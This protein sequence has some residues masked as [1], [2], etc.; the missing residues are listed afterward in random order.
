[1]YFD[2]SSTFQGGG[3][4]VVLT[5]LFNQPILT[6]R[7][8]ASLSVERKSSR[9]RARQSSLP[10]DYSWDIT[11]PICFKRK[12]LSDKVHFLVSFIVSGYLESN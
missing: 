11:N 8:S 2:G 3:I 6:I 1:M 5:W 7:P 12:P 10:Y 4:G 9:G